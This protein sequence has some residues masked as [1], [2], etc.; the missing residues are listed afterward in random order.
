MDGLV[1]QDPPTIQLPGAAPAARV[2]VTLR[3]PPPHVGGARGQAAELTPGERLVND[4]RSGVEAVLA[5][6]GDPPARGTL[7]LD[8]AVRRL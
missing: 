1:D 3:S 5:Y 6:D 4:V 8:Q 2:V 7:D